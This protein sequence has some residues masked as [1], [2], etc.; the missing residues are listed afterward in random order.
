MR[1]RCKCPRCRESVV[2]EG[3]STFA[4]AVLGGGLVLVLATC[5]LAP[6][7]GFLL[8][9]VAPVVAL[10]GLG[11]GPLVAAATAP[12]TCPNCLVRIEV[13]PVRPEPLA[14]QSAAVDARAP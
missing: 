5:L 11:L 8:F 1:A 10:V 9:G 4:R 3:P 14:L 6:Y 13:D 7:L 2:P 12:V